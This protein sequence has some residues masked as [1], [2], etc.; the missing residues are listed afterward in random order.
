MAQPVQ[1]H[2]QAKS[3]AYFAIF[4]EETGHGIH[5]KI[6]G[7]LDAARDAGWQA[8]GEL[9]HAPGLGTHLRLGR[10]IAAA[11]EEVLI[12]RSTAHHLFVLMPYLL[13]ARRRGR[14]LVLDVPTP[15]RAA[16]LELWRSRAPLPTRLRKTL[17]L[18]ATG[19]VP[20]W[21]FHRIVQY[22]GEGGWWRLGNARRTLT[23]GN[24][25]NLKAVPVRDSAPPWPADVLR[26]IAVANVSFWHGYDRVLRAMRRVEE[27]GLAPCPLELTIVGA[28]EMLPELRR[29][30][31]ELGITDRVHFVGP[32]FGESLRELYRTH[33]VGV[34]SL[35]LHRKRLGGAAEL[36]AREYCAVGIPFVAGGSDPDFD[37][38][39]GFRFQVSQSESV[40]DVA[41]ALGRIARSGSLPATAEI[42]AWAEARLD[43]SRKF[44][45]I[46]GGPW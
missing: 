28:G 24:G 14:T 16:V 35:A 41:D 17:L 18:L 30:A 3:V 11:S 10:A 7:L 20:A 26:L 38:A 22:A 29:L 23:T 34:A 45:Q 40:E 33:H 27:R 21:P 6:T 19:P 31:L 42:R 39:A 44:A 8:R 1:D 37:A 46:V 13:Q 25:I 32:L 43:A 36:K 15:H 5:R 12:V 2:A 4:A 9:L